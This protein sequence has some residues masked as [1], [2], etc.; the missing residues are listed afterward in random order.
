MDYWITDQIKMQ[1]VIPKKHIDSIQDVKKED[2][3]I[4]SKIYEVIQKLAEE[5]E[6]AQ[7][8][9]RVITNCRENGGQEVK[10]LH[11]HLLGGAKLGTKMC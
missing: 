10:H 2:L 1:L 11:F 8:G 3:V 5:F 7:E 4:I 6:I 9:Y